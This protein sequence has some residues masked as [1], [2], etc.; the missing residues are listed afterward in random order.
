M[1]E[2][3]FTHHSVKYNFLLKYSWLMVLIS[4]FFLCVFLGSHWWHM[5]VSRFGVELELYLL[6]YTTATETPD[7]SCIYELHHG[8]WQCWMLNLLSK[9]RDWTYILM[10]TSQVHYYWATTGTPDF[11]CTAKWFSYIY[12]YIYVCMCV[13]VCVYN[14]FHY[15]LS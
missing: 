9:A 13:Y 14:L 15:G 4:F 5:E 10:D 7:L 2:G 1:A 12:I 11:W 6:A 8:S 3:I